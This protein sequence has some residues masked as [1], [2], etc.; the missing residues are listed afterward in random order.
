MQ[1]IVGTWRLV[2]T[3][4]FTD[5]GSDYPP[6]YGNE[7]GLGRVAFT[8]DGRMLAVLYNSAATLPPGEE[9]E[10][11]AYSGN[12]TFDGQRLV[13]DVVA[14]SDAGRL[15][16]RQVRDVRFDGPYMIFRPPVRTVGARKVQREMWFEKIADV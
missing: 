3:F 13:T 11:N 14:N 9:R 16:G 8:A 15:G 4:A 7:A 6:P 5:D 1:S 2:K 12:Y 10:F